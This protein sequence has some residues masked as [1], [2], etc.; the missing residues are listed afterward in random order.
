MTSVQTRPMSIDEFLARPEQEKPSLE[1]LRGEVIEKPMVSE[2]HGAVVMELGRLIG[3]YLRE[4]REGRVVTEVR[5]AA[6]AQDW[7]FL[8]DLNVRL[9][10]AGDAGPQRRGAV[11]GA[12]D[13]AV[14]VLSP[15]DRVS[16]WLERVALYME[17]GTQLLWVV[18]PDDETVRVYRPGEQ[19]RTYR[20]GDTIDASPVLKDFRLDIA[21][22]FADLR[23]EAGA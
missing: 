5:H 11:E 7:V 23:E 8:P 14:E 21:A 22:F 1:F 19:P 12:P 17:A 18:D 9:K 13:M 16:R 3:N 20:P 4:S 15:D 2:M 6:R 10:R